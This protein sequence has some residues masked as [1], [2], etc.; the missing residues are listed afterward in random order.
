MKRQ[1]GG[2]IHQ[3]QH[4][5]HGW[6]N[7]AFEE[8]CGEARGELRDLLGHFKAEEKAKRTLGFK[9]KLIPAFML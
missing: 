1:E 6:H 5:H 4:R 9:G 8:R 7:E 2:S 3:E